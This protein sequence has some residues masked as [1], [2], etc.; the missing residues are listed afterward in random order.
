MQRYTVYF[1]WKLLYMFRVVLPPI[2]RSA[3]N[4]IY[5]IW[6]LSHRYCYLLLSWKSWNR[7]ECATQSTLKPVPTLPRYIHSGN[8][9]KLIVFSGDLFLLYFL[10]SVEFSSFFRVLCYTA[11]CYTSLCYTAL[12]Y[13][14]LCY[15]ALCY[16]ALCYAALCY[17]ALCYTALCYAA[18][19]YAPLCYTALCYTALCYTALC[20]TALCYTALCYTALCYTALCYTALCYTALC[21][22]ALCYTA[23]CY[24]ALCYTAL[25]CPFVT[26]ASVFGNCVFPCIICLVHIQRILF[27]SHFHNILSDICTWNFRTGVLDLRTVTVGQCNQIK[28]H[29][30]CLSVLI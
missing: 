1:I 18:L 7:F 13:T 9:V 21:Y 11:L 23:L 6:Y 5:S 17:T 28:W 29:H 27:I 24:T 8:A 15:A 2:I 22:T 12:C 26:M 4:C 14:A 30:V 16:A 25:C 20:Y 10:S 3:N 19:C